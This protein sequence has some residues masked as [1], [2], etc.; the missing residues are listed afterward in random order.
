[1]TPERLERTRDIPVARNGGVEY[2]QTDHGP[3][4]DVAAGPQTFEGEVTELVPV[5]DFKSGGSWLWSGKVGSIPML[6]RQQ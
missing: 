3:V 6:S 1:M 2:N 4:D 5:P